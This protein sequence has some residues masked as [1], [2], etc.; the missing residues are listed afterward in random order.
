MKVRIAFLLAIG[1]WIAATLPSAAF[2]QE[3]SDV[4]FAR[5]IALIRGHLLTGDELAGQG[6]WDA[7][8]THSSFPR[9]EIYGI[10]REQLA[11]YKTPQFDDAFKVMVRTVKARNAKQY[12]K[13]RVQ[14]ENALAAADAG[15]KAKTPN[16]PRFVVAIAIEVLKTAPDEYNDAIAKGRIV[17]P[18]GYQTARGFV[19]QAEWMFESVTD[20]FTGDNAAAL[21]D[22]RARFA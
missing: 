2:A 4:A 7:G 10:I 18:I 17:R 9:E 22:I 6:E 20:E 8:S 15:L 14:V 19:L 21:S 12:Q 13:A 1:G 11:T 16:W 5:F 3:T